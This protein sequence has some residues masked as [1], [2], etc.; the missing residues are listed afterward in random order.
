M[1]RRGGG[2]K[3]NLIPKKKNNNC[4]TKTEGLT[5]VCPPAKETW[6]A[7]GSKGIT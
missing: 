2:D 5:Q 6:W 1:R 7:F 4:W 3:K